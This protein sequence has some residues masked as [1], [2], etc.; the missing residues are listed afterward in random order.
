MEFGIGHHGEP[1]V[2]VE[3]IRDARGMAA[4]MVKAVCEDA[5][6]ERGD[7]VVLLVSGLGATPV[8]EQYIFSASVFDELSERN[9]SVHRSYVGNYFTSLEMSG[10]TLTMMRL[11]DELRECIDMPVE[12]P[13]LV[14]R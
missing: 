10:I 2:R 11:D 5:P 6:F 4:E 7:E 3:P 12:T 1:G 13:A 14:Q 9:I 8:M